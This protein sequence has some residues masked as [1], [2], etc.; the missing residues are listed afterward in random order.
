MPS[1]DLTGQ[2]VLITGAGRG[3][4]RGMALALASWG[5]RTGVVDID[6][7]GAAETLAL[8]ERQGGSGWSAQL[9]VTDAPSVA[10][11]VADCWDALGGIDLLVNNA[12][13][14]S[15]SLVVDLDPAEWRRV[16]EV[17]ATG[18]FLV[19]QS[20]VRKMIE[21]GRPGS[22][23]SISSIGGKR[24]DANI[25]HYNASKFAVIGF[26][27]ALAREVARHDILVNAVCPGVVETKMIDDMARGVG[28]QV[29]EWIDIQAIR[30]SQS[31]QDIALAVAFLHRSRAMTG[32]SINVDGGTVFH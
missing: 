5:A 7:A 11:V 26:T 12:G 28:V 13:V 2:K 32:Q 18:V 24:G 16:M 1:F 21:H 31:P 29:Q 27:Q 25:A 19:S 4:G 15:V 23:V 9:D 14:L 3:I 30:R 22:V 17:N 6:A 10:R 8:I 20:V